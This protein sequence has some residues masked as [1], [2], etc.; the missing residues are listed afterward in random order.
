MIR[1]FSI[2]RELRSPRTG[3][4]M[5]CAAAL[6]AA[7]CGSSATTSGSSTFGSGG[8]STFLAGDSDVFHVTGPE[9]GPFPEGRREYWIK[10][11][12]KH[13]VLRWSVAA[14]IPWLDFSE[15]GG[16]LA[17]GAQTTVLAQIDQAIAESLAPGDYPADIVF[18]DARSGGGEVY[19]S[20]LLTVTSDSGEGSALTVT[21]L[22]DYVA[23]ATV[24]GSV[25]V[26][27]KV[28]TVGNEGDEPVKW[29]A[30]VTEDWLLLPDSFNGVLQPGETDTVKVAISS[31]VTGFVAGD[32]N[33]K[34]LFRNVDT[35]LGDTYREVLL[36]VHDGNGEGRVTAGLQTLY[37][38][39]EGSGT[40]VR[41][42][43]GVG[44]PT[45]LVIEDP[46]GVA[47][48][49]GGLFFNGTT[50]AMT[51][52]PATTLTQAL[53]S[54][55]S[56]SLEAWI[57]PD[58]VTQEGPARIMTLSDGSYLRNFTL[59]QGLWGGQ[60][61]DT[62][63]VR[64]RTTATDLDGMPMVTTAAG[65]AQEGL[66]HVV[67]T[68]HADGT[69]RIYVNSVLKASDTVGG[70]LGN[71]D[72]QYAFALGNEIGAS[73]PWR[74]A[75]Q[76]AAVYDRALTAAEVQQ[77]FEAGTGDAD[78]GRILVDP[79]SDFSVY[80]LVGGKEMTATSAV[81]NI[82]NPG[83]ET[84]EWSATSSETWV[85]L[86]NPDSGSL[87]P[88]ETVALT[89]EL[90]M[91]QISGFSK[92]LYTAKVAFTNLTNGWGSTDRSVIV[93]I[94]E[95]GDGNVDGWPGPETTPPYTG[96][97][98][99]D[100]LAS[101]TPSGSVKV[102]QDGAV[103]ENLDVSGTIKVEAKDVT[104][105]N[106]RIDGGGGSAYGIH[107]L[108]ATNLTIEKVEIVRN[109]SAGVY[110]RNFTLTEANI[111]EQGGDGIKAEGNNLIEKCW[112]HHLGMIE[113]AHAD[114]SQT[115]GGSN[116]VFRHNFFDMPSPS[117]PN[118]EGPPY[119]SN[120]TFF[121]GAETSDISGVIIEDNLLNGG[122]YTIYFGAHPSTGY[123]VYDCLIRNNWFLRD[124][125]YGPLYTNPYES[126]PIYGNRWFDTKQ[127]MD[128]ND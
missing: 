44:E 21:P 23:N 124:F 51:Q 56:L 34:V 92:G 83:Q 30:E 66:Q 110:G 1:N 32:Y 17:P 25:D 102:T 108:Y 75:L 48:L 20:F 115:R 2:H 57:V 22:E 10:N 43:S 81:Y 45:D 126:S 123:K 88:G 91:G 109:T 121:I 13:S 80:G 105:R 69:A 117:S 95:E 39:S 72:T 29:F 93:S 87:A 127:L 16:L 6:V 84:V 65:A 118:G 119:K 14:T 107:A 49:P 112:I 3:L 35:G 53:K 120:A 114:G 37:N 82:S 79:A 94:G 100:W 60:P 28:Y 98:K 59:G 58:N 67:Y 64:L 4:V 61:S 71:W 128:I 8:G 27:E 46:S 77:N 26:P 19:L 54:A 99:S 106:C 12:T 116:I 73:R 9:G 122:N 18:R 96:Q 101:L 36:S 68:R 33:G 38:F 76:L 104:I 78:V 125:K 7:S 11:T 103:I 50:R 113:G 40:L 111:H 31:D 85:T 55:N 15:K 24:G 47:W 86:S 41:D 74:G 63:N 5:A 70:D 62:F 52:G 90:D 97:K 89:V 42:T